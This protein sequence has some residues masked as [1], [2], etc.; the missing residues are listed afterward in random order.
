MSCSLRPDAYWFGWFCRGRCCDSTECEG[1]IGLA[2]F[3]PQ[4]FSSLTAAP[5]PDLEDAVVC[6]KPKECQIG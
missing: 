4:F 6:E 2:I 1:R 5:L 3:V